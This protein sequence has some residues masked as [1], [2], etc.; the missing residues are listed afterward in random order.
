MDCRVGDGQRPRYIGDDRVVIAAAGNSP[1][2]GCDGVP[3]CLVHIRVTGQGRFCGQRVPTGETGR[4]VG[5]SG[6]RI[7]YIGLL[8][9]RFDGDAGLADG[10]VQGQAPNI[11][12]CISKRNGYGIIPRIGGRAAESRAVRFCVVVSEAA[13]IRRGRGCAGIAVVRAAIVGAVLRPHARDCHRGFVGDGHGGCPGGG[14]V[15]AIHS[16]GGGGDGDNCAYCRSSRDIEAIARQSLF[17]P[18]PD[19]ISKAGIGEAVRKRGVMGIFHRAVHSDFPPCNLLGGGGG[20]GDLRRGRVHGHTGIDIRRGVV[21][22]GI[23][24]DKCHGESPG[25]CGLCVSVGP[26]PAS[27]NG[28]VPVG[29]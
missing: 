10:E 13:A 2:A 26:A 21:V 22:C 15:L 8:I 3:A 28:G 9:V 16:G 25:C 14:G 17:R 4:G 27:G 7:A 18:A 24:G 19:P 11:G 23:A 12:T 5:Q 20:Q 1:A 6:P 29:V